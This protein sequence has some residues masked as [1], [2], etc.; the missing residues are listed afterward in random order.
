M[1]YEPESSAQTAEG[2][3]A[4][5]TRA[6][7]AADFAPNP[8]D[9]VLTVLLNSPAEPDGFTMALLRPNLALDASGHLLLLRPGDFAAF[10]DAVEAV[11]ERVPHTSAFMGQW[12]VKQP[13]T[14][15]PIDRVFIG[16][17]EEERAV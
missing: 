4:R 13:T 16:G 1:S 2:W 5:A 7:S 17:E 3:H 6:S 15:R 10:E 9:L 14:C 11:R 12:R 8:S